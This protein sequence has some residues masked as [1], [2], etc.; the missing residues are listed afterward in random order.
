MGI[1]MNIDKDMDMGMDIRIDMDLSIPAYMR[2]MASIASN[3][4]CISRINLRI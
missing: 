4:T 3:S 2:N 1:G